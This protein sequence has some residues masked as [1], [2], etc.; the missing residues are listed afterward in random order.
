MLKEAEST[1]WKAESLCKA[2]I[3]DKR[4]LLFVG[5]GP[6]EIELETKEHTKLSHIRVIGFIQIREPVYEVD[7]EKFKDI[8]HTVS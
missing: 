6:L 3:A 5:S 4:V 2:R 1:K 8:F 7:S